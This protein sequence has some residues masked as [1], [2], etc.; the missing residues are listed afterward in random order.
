MPQAI[1][2]PVLLRETVEALGCVRGGLWVD[3]TV[4]GGGHARAILDAT[5]PDGRLIGVDRDRTALDAARERLGSDEGRVTLRHAD[6]RHLPQ[7]LETLAAPPADG[8][9]LDLGVSSLQIDDPD[10]GFSFQTDGP[11]DMRMDRSQPGTAADLVRTLPGPEIERLLRR[12][13]EEPRAARMA[14][15]IV[16][17]REREPIATTG[18]LARI[19]A[20][21]AGP[22]RGRVRLHPATRAFQALRIAVNRE[23]EGLDGTL[24]SLLLRLRPGG[25][26]VVIAFHSLEDRIVKR[27]FRS[28]AR[29]CV[30]PPRLPICACGRPDLAR[31]VTARPVRPGAAEI[32]DN[33]RSRSARLRAAER[34][35]DGAAARPAA[36]G[37]AR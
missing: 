34:L 23:L 5:A 1:H 24:E 19:V 25:R 3:G 30:C 32:R 2:Q 35:A 37:G 27:T 4:G 18:R 36:G 20:A 13:G 29:R 21:A 15:A 33:P 17:E 22:P 6:Y 8:I 16:R 7:L 14:R 10:R 9:L 11:L 26:L 31:V 28:L 12:F